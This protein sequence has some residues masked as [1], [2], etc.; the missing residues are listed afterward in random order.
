M[1]HHH[2][3]VEPHHVAPELMPVYR[4]LSDAGHHLEEWRDTGH[5]P[6]KQEICDIQ[7][8]LSWVDAHYEEGSFKVNGKAPEGQAILATKLN[9]AR[10]ILHQFESEIR[11]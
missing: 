1:T 6:T 11:D 3:H 10:T 5:N 4:R 8:K 2:H 9:N 7:N